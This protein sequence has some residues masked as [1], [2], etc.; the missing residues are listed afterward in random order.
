[1]EEL[2]QPVVNKVKSWGDINGLTFNPK[3]T[4][5]TMFTRRKRVRAP[6]IKLGN[7]ALELADS[8]KYLGVEIQRGL[9]WERHITTRVNK[10][11]GL[12]FKCKGI[13][14]R[15]WGLTPEKIDWIYKAIV[16]PK[17]TYGSIVWGHRMTAGTTNKLTSLQRIAIV[18]TVQPLRSSPTAGLEVMMGWIP[19]DLHVKEMGLNA[20][21]RLQSNI[22]S[23]WDHI[24]TQRKMMGHIGL[25]SKE[26]RRLYPKSYPNVERLDY[27]VW[28]PD[29]H[30]PEVCSHFPTPIDIYTDASK[31]GNNVG[32]G[33]LVCDGNFVIAEG[34]V[35][36]KDINVYQAEILAIREVLSW[37][38][39]EGSRERRYIIHSDSESAV[40][41]L[42]GCTV[43]DYT[44][45]ETMSLLR[46]LGRDCLIK[47]VWVKGHDDNVGNVL[48]DCL[49]QRGMK[50][51]E[52][53]MYA[54]PFVPVCPGQ[55]KRAL[56]QL[57]LERWQKR[58]DLLL[59]CKISH[60]FKPLVGLNKGIIKF[61][62]EE[63]S[64]LSQ[65]ITGHGLFKRHL[66]HWNE[67][68]DIQCS[69]CEED[70]ESSWHL[71]EFCPRL[72]QTRQLV[73]S[74][75]KQG[76]SYEKTLLRFF[77]ERAL[78]ELRAQ[79]EAMIGV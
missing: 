40:S 2:L 53:L 58:W 17:L 60:L 8:I 64:M 21:T 52:M 50:E 54:P 39:E 13:I 1:M 57:M 72:Q 43:K 48:A 34:S 25:W 79:N 56:R 67:I 7:T 73:S 16:R 78:V 61:S 31:A 22:H 15:N 29:N 32:L 35:P 19:L 5:M 46:E 76:I 59:S 20:F 44:V 47:I 62:F 49:A 66:R 65:I 70:Q 71:W 69:L 30:V 45:N 26:L 3:K 38:K 12:L 10:C 24:G 14:N 63:L 77:H 74:L 36:L 28:Y 33:W 42:N 23:K 37:I 51:A 27:R 41:T 11:K 18:A 68:G 4:Q 75:T 9:N 6:R 55:M